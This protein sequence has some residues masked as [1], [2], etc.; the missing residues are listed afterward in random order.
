MVIK[1]E[2]IKEPIEELPPFSGPVNIIDKTSGE[3]TYIENPIDLQ[4]KAVKKKSNK[5]GRLAALLYD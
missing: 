4:E 1:I 2:D 5:K 3:S